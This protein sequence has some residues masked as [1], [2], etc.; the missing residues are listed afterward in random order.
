M[1]GGDWGWKEQNFA[2]RRVGGGEEGPGG[3]IPPSRM[4]E[5]SL[6]DRERVNAVVRDETFRF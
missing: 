3:K 1:E 6:G 5:G 2:G 4:R